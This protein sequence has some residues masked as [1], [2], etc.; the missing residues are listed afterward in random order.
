NKLHAPVIFHMLQPARKQTDGHPCMPETGFYQSVNKIL[1]VKL[2]QSFMK[3]RR[4]GQTEYFAAVHP[5]NK[6]DF[7]MRQSLPR[8]GIDNMVVF[9]SIGFKEFAAGRRVEK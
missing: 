1:P 5:Q 7:I 4:G 2:K 3:R 9:S 6:H 8:D